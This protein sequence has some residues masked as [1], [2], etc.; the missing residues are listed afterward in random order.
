MALGF[1]LLD[2][3]NKRFEDVKLGLSG[4]V[5]CFL[6]FL[7]TTKQFNAKIL[8]AA[9]RRESH[10]HEDLLLFAGGDRRVDILDF[11]ETGN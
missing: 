1:G 6:I 4:L 8:V 9:L 3:Q 2:C 10:K 7:Y 11:I 5:T